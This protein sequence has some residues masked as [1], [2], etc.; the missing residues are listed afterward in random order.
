MSSPLYL[1]SEEDEKKKEDQNGEKQ[2]TGG[3]VGI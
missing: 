1:E 3:H 2:Q